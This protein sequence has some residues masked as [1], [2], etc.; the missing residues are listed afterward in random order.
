MINKLKQSKAKDKNIAIFIDFT[1]AYNTVI[2]TKLFE[3]IEKKNIL[4]PEESQFLKELYDQ[5]YFQRNQ[6]KVYLKNGLQ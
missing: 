4:A 3:I 2:R 5:V 6:S 1:A